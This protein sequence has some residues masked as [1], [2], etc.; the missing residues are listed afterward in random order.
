MCGQGTALCV[1]SP[2]PL[3]DYAEDQG[4][5]LLLPPHLQLDFK[6]IFTFLL[7]AANGMIPHPQLQLEFI[8]ILCSLLVAVFTQA[9]YAPPLL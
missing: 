9:S 7:L 8:A 2:T 1:V 6:E 3:S 5:L 4:N